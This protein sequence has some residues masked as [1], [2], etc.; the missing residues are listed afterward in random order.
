MRPS[1]IF[2]SAGIL[3]YLGDDDAHIAAVLG[4]EVIYF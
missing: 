1:E 4:H 3:E 2:V